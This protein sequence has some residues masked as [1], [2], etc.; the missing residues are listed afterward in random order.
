MSAFPDRPLDFVAWLGTQ[1]EDALVPRAAFGAYIAHHLRAA[2]IPNGLIQFERTTVVDIIP[3]NTQFLI[4]CSNGEHFRA[5]NLTLALG[6]YPADASIVPAA[7]RNHPNYLNDPWS[8]DP[9][10]IDGDI[11]CIGSGL[12]A[13][14]ACVTLWTSGFSHKIRLLSRHGLLPL[15][16]DPHSKAVDYPAL[17]LDARS[18]FALLRSFRRAARAAAADGVDW[19]SLIEA[20]R[21]PSPG[22]WQAWT[23]RDRK[24]FL[25][26]LQAYWSVHRYRVPPQTAAIC[27]EL[28]ASG[29]L[30]RH[31]GIIKRAGTVGELMTIHTSDRGVMQAIETRYVLNCTGP[32]SDYACNPDRLVQSLLRRGLIR[33][34]AL[35]LGI[36]LLHPGMYSLGPPLRGAYYES[37]AVPEIRAQALALARELATK[38]VCAN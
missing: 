13:M 37:T 24:R 17:E 22:I 6:N 20:L 34:D 14:D 38:G 31:R 16:E 3:E 7:I 4:T 12:T 36:E 29:Q 2:C 9:Y 15:L 11:L 25:R 8:I 19:R 33:G 32:Q 18:P 1:T 21:N 35:R 26:H 27:Y 23:L 10:R 5:R 28:M 30:L